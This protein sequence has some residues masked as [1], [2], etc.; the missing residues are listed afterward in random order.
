MPGKDARASRGDVVKTS[1][2]VV[3]GSVYNLSNAVD[4]KIQDLAFRS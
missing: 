4:S 2:L 1:P 3:S